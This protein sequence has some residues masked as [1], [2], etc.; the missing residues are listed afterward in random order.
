M[1]PLT[2]LRA[3]WRN[4]FTKQRAERELDEELR[5][6]AALLADEMHRGGASSGDAR[7]LA[8]AELGGV[9]RVKDDVRDVRSGALVE[10]MLQDVR[11]AA[12]A[13]VRRPSFTIVAVS[14]LALGIGATTAIF[15]VVNGVLLRPLPY[16]EPDRLV[17][18]LHNSSD[19]VAPA[20]YL[21]WRRLNTVFSSVG[22][23][24]YWGGNVVGDVA[25]RV[26]GLRVTSDIL[27]MTGVAPILGRTLLP[28][29]ETEGAER[30]AVLAWGYW[31]RRFAG[32]P[33]VLDQR[34]TVDGTSYRIVGVM[35]PGF[36]FPM[37][38]ATGVQIWSPLTFGER[39]TSRRGSSLRVFARLAPNV[40]IEAARS[41]MAS[42]T[43]NLDREFPGTNRDVTVTPLE[44]MVVGNVKPALIVLLV[45][46]AFVLLI[47][48][49]NVAHMLLA[50]ASARHREINVRLALGASRRRLLR[51]LLTESVVL[52]L[53]GGVVGVVLARVGLTM[54]LGLSAGSIPRADS[55]S[56]DTG[57]LVFTA[58]VSLAT[59]LAFGLLP[60]LRVS[61]MEVADALRD[62]ARGST[63]GVQRGRLRSM[64]VGSE[65]ALAL[66]L[67]AAAGLA[68]RSFTAL[69]AIDP[70][71]EPRGVLSAMVTV[72][73]TAEEAP[74]RR[75]AFYTSVL[76]RIRQL[77]GVESASY[78]NHLPI[79]GDV[80]GLGFRVEGRPPQ[81]PGEELRAAYRVV[82]P[83]YF[84][85]MRLP[86]LR[87]RGI[88]ERDRSG[89]TPV[90]V[91]NDWFARRH[92]PNGD[93]LGKRITL[94]SGEDPLWVTVVGVSKN[95]VRSD[96]SAPPEEELFLPYHQTARYTEGEGGH[97]AYMTLV[98]RATCPRFRDC[99]PARL[100][101][102][103]RE[104]V[105]SL[106]R[107]VPVTEVQPMMA[108]VEGANA[109]PR[110][111]L[112]L[113]GTFAAVA[114]VLA[115]VGIYGVI[116]Y[117]VSRRTHEIG[118]RMALGAS[119]RS[120]VRLIVGQGMLVVSLGAVAGVAGAL[121]VTRLMTSVVYGVRVTD[122]PTY[123]TVTLL[124]VGV[125]L[126]AS[127]IPA[128]RAT[129][130]DPLTAIRTE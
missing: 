6:Y 18:L 117:A 78:I 27:R 68:M 96:W 95:A 58:V 19:P 85:T 121:V 42:I 120:V 101:S 10:T 94:D 43:G 33:Q 105:G 89:S 64:L 48:C 13:L 81:Q 52:G 74:G 65:I 56:V 15:S 36:D 104:V 108:V 77:P 113:L 123:V 92:W 86:I 8:L 102:A 17:A 114:L 51:Q 57:V 115:A 125:A 90:V 60:A 63:E 99:E 45:A 107:A 111:T 128:R 4:L 88:D 23:A 47:A 14:A 110:L 130:V 7:R 112:V 93:A 37:F 11:Y 91:V 83:G 21:D 35:P 44:T 98:A 26:Q 9:E 50:R 25:E 49:A 55:V 84:E 32:S 69:R 70:G 122:P 1:A 97:V 82:F 73:G 31:Q 16:V 3:L 129:K 119:P 34:V 124:L 59:G 29:D 76:D 87:G 38:W 71:F 61:R 2:R 118:V 72:R 80:W 67:L 53:A 12:R 41:Q 103:V 62:G 126:L 106:N 100:A 46:V 127:Y 79:G 39:A 30:T 109:R 66:V 116:S 22:A 24:E 54:L 5:S 20:N 40:T 75:T 28:E